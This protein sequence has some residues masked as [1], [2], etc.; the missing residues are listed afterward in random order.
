M[1]LDSHNC[2]LCVENVEE[3]I[4]HLFF[5]C[6]FAGA[7]WI[8]LDIHWDTS[9]D[10]Q[11]MLLRARERFDSVIFTEVVIMAMWAL[12]THGN[13]IIFYDGFLSFAWWRKTFFE[14]MKAVT[15]RVQSPLKDKILAWLSSLQLS[16]L[17]FYFGPRA[18]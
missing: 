14:G 18:L 10:F 12:W 7:C 11:T 4:M 1:Q 13:S 15:L 8:Y 5:E 3:D 2:V 16:F 17:F 6:P 9:L